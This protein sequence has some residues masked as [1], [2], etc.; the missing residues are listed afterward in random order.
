VNILVILAGAFTFLAL[1]F[2]HTQNIGFI[3]LKDK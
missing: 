1:A 2:S 3:P